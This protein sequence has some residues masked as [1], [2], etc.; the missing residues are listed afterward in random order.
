M[1]LVINNDFN[2]EITV[3]IE[4]HETK[5]LQEKVLQKQLFKTYSVSG[6]SLKNFSKINE[7]SHFYLSNAILV[8]YSVELITVAIKA[9]EIRLATG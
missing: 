1:F 7:Y 9:N 8:V 4:R 5:Y 2:N 6:R 3:I